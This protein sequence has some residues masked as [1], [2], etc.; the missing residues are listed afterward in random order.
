MKADRAKQVMASRQAAGFRSFKRVLRL[1][2]QPLIGGW[3]TLAHPA[4]A[5]ILG[6]AGF[7]WLAIDLEHSVISF[8]EAE[9]LIRVIVLCGSTPLVRLS[10]NDPVQIKRVMDAGAHGV[11][12]PMVNS[13]SDAQRAVAAVYYPPRGTRGVGLA[14]AQG[15]GAQ[16]DTYRRWLDREPVVIVQIEHRDAVQHFRDIVTVPGVDG[17]LLGSYDISASMGVP[18]Q[19]THPKV[20]AALAQVRR[21][22]RQLKVPGGMHVIQPDP[23]EVKRR[24]REGFQLIAYSLDILLLG[25]TAR[26]GLAVVRDGLKRYKA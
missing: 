23:R 26:E 8:R 15:Y 1:G 5:E 11:I 12:V 3:I 2:R 17:Y 18:G 20:T 13:R 9:E 22:A 6:K 10:A 25:A 14:R 16:F 24:I 21:L 4:I 7:D 19:L